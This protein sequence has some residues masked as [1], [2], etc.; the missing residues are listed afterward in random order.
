MSFTLATLIV[1]SWFVT[2][3]DGS[4][5]TITTWLSP[6]LDCNGVPVRVAVLSP[7][8]VKVKKPGNVDAVILLI[9]LSSSVI[10]IL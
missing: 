2:P 4:V 10:V 6:R 7:L 9:S 1:N 8:S 3:P 5:A